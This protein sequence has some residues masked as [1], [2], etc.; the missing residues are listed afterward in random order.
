M[1]DK[2]TI[3]CAICSFSFLLYH[4]S[5]WLGYRKGLNDARKILEELLKNKEGKEE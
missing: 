3:L 4:F 2:I 1:Y 5:H